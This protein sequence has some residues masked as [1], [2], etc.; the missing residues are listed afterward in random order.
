MYFECSIGKSWD[1]VILWG[2]KSFSDG[3]IDRMFVSLTFFLKIFFNPHLRTFF[4]CFFRDRRREGERKRNIDGREKHQL[5]SHT[6]PIW[7]SNP[8]PGY[9]PWP[10]IEPVTFWFMGQCSN[11]LIDLHWPGLCP[12]NSNFE[13][14]SPVVEVL[15]DRAFGRW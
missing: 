1:K 6:H 9:M 8:Q 2:I 7:G 13:T 4:H 3:A 15:R 10:G 5:S 14:Q 11:Q 12:P